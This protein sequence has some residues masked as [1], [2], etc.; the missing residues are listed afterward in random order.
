MEGE[1]KVEAAV[2]EKK[3]RKQYSRRQPK[4]QVT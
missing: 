3:P 1:E 4:P 2:E